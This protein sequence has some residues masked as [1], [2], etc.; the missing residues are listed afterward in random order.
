MIEV[1]AEAISHIPEEH[2]SLQ[3]LSVHFAQNLTMLNMFPTVVSD[4]HL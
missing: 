1:V 3:F 2:I 4:F